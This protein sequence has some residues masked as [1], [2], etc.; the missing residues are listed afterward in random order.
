MCICT[1]SGQWMEPLGGL[2]ERN[3]TMNMKKKYIIIEVLLF[4]VA[5]MISYFLGTRA[6]LGKRTLGYI[7]K[8]G[9]YL[10]QVQGKVEVC[11][12]VKWND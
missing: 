12:P 2:Y 4:I 7:Y 11:L 1:L 8:N 6:A 3:S 10:S 5:I 9:G